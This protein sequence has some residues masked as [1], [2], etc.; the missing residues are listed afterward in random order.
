MAQMSIAEALNRAIAEEMERDQRVFCI[1]EDISDANGGYGGA[2]AVTRRL[3][4]R[5]G[6]ERVINTPISE[7]LICGVA[8]GA[9]M[10]GLIPIADLQ[11][12]DFLFCLMDQLANQAAKMCYM[13]GGKVHVP[14]VLRAPIGATT[15]GSQHGQSLEGCFTHIPGLKVICPGTAYDAMGL[16]KT[17][18]RD[19]NPVLV[20]EH[21]RLYG[22]KRTERQALSTIG[23]VPDGDFTIPFGQAVVRRDGSHI[24]LVANLLMM[25]RAME[26]AALLD[27]EGIQCEVIDPRTLV[28]F[29]YATVIES[30]RKTGRLL[31]VHE[32]H[33]TNGWGAQLAAYIAENEIYLLDAPIRRVAAYDVPVPFA[34]VMEN[35]VVPTAERIAEAARSLMKN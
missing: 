11:Y 31:I 3:H 9:A 7:I 4:D 20:F 27:K 1:G 14:M 35:F 12:G 13:S 5:F 8:V 22:G 23:E 30:L 21:K 24:T 34:P 32:D 25:Y 28:P 2:F 26:A 33:Y 18:I 6:A 16:L 29:D 15:R 17:A 10:T 19:G